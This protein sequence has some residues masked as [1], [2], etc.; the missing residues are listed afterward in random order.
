M[1]LSKAL[2]LEMSTDTLLYHR[3]TH[4]FKIGDTIKPHGIGLN[5]K[6]FYIERDNV[7]KFLEQYRPANKPSRGNSVYLS[8]I[9]KS[10]FIEKGTL[11][12]CK[13]ASNSK[14]HITNSRLVDELYDRIDQYPENKNIAETYWKPDKFQISQSTVKDIEIL[15]D[16]VIVVDIVKEQRDYNKGD[17][18]KLK[19]DFIDIHKYSG[20]DGIWLYSEDDVNKHIEASKEDKIKLAKKIGIKLIIAGMETK[21]T[22]PKG[23]K[24]KVSLIRL[25]VPGKRQTYSKSPYSA[26]MFRTISNPFFQLYVFPSNLDKDENFSQV[27]EKI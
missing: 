9:K 2:L 21:L 8:V 11:Y 25:N 16:K 6:H 4:N 5:N 20:I 7:E 23:M 13:I 17:I 12:V 1:K 24:L 22:F 26:I 3:S 27:F 18:V 19:K 14:W 10:R 15:A